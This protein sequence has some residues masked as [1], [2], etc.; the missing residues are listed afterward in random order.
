VL[1][2]SLLQL[3]RKLEV[4]HMGRGVCAALH[5]WLSVICG[6]AWFVREGAGLIGLLCKGCAVDTA[7]LLLHL[8]SKSVW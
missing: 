4:H 3:G 5:G 2:H 6:V 7:I 1:P 8:G